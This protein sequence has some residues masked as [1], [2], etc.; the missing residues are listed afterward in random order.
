MKTTHQDKVTNAI[1]DICSDINRRI[2][3]MDYYQET[4][5]REYLFNEFNEYQKDCEQF[6][7]YVFEIRDIAHIL[8]VNI[9]CIF[10]ILVDLGYA[11]YEEEQN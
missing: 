7:L 4:S 10:D 9:T 1:Q 8:D 11:S 2:I 5:V 6:M 3:R